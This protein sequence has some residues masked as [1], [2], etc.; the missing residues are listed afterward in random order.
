[1]LQ[2]GLRV[3]L[4]NGFRLPLRCAGLL[5]RSRTVPLYEGFSSQTRMVGVQGFYFGLV[6]ATND[7]APY[8]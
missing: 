2:A 4:E 3:A 6:L 1:M 7:V 8:T 5:L